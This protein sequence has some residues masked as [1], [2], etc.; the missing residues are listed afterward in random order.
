MNRQRLFVG[1]L[2]AI[3]V[4]SPVVVSAQSGGNVELGGFG[5]FTRNDAAWHV[6]NGFG[7]G[8]RLGV[9]FTPRWELEADASFSS[10][11]NEP[12]RATGS[13]SAQTFAGRLTYGIPFG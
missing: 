1:A 3:A 7:A 2:V 6:K 5:Q 4:A 9:F 8:G 10:F 13:T 11:T 12:P